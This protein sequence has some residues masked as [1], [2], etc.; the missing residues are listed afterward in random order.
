MGAAEGCVSCQPQPRWLSLQ[1]SLR[2]RSFLA[3]VLIGLLVGRCRI[4]RLVPPYGL[5]G[6]PDGAGSTMDPIP[7]Q[8]QAFMLYH[9]L[10]QHYP[11]ALQC[12]PFRHGD[13]GYEPRLVA[14]S[15]RSMV[16]RSIRAQEPGPHGP[17]P[18]SDATVRNR[19][20]ASLSSRCQGGASGYRGQC[21]GFPGGVGGLWALG[22]SP[23]TGVRVSVTF[24]GGRK[25]RPISLNHVRSAGAKEVATMAYPQQVISE[26]SSSLSSFTYFCEESV[27]T[28]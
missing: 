18:G 2:T 15:R 14:G 23:L 27:S 21:G 13:E 22:A 12:R 16:L 28:G 4:Q 24:N 6:D 8:L 9:A 26:K 1:A 11:D 17:W 20:T 25:R 3:G 19:A 10:R 7:K 5:A